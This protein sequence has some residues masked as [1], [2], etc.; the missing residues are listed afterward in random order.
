MDNKIKRDFLVILANAPKKAIQEYIN[1]LKDEQAK[2][3]AENL[4]R[5]LKIL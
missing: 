5:A 4:A 3:D 1:G 2:K